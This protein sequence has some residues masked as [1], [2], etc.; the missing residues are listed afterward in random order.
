[1]DKSEALKDGR[2][3][4]KIDDDAQALYSREDADKLFYVTRKD[5]GRG[6]ASIEERVPIQEVEEDIN[7]REIDR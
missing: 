2:Q 6:L 7:K 1:M 3:K 5:E 4:K